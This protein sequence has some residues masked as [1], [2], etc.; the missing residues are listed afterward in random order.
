MFNNI[1]V[2]EKVNMEIG[3]VRIYLGTQNSA[4]QEVLMKEL[5]VDKI[6]IDI[7]MVKS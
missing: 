6:Y 3:Y 2:E 4:R 5:G 1:K 7:V